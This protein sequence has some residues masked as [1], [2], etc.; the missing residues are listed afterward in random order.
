MLNLNEEK[1]NTGEIIINNINHGQT[2]TQNNIP[3]YKNSN[4]SLQN[5]EQVQY[6]VV[7]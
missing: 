1:E 3:D 4:N 2:I 6:D 7:V 5:I